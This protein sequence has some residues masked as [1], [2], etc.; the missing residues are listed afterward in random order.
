M[1][2]QGAGKAWLNEEESNRYNL[3]PMPET[4]RRNVNWTVVAGEHAMG[5]QLVP[6]SRESAG[7]THITSA[8]LSN[9]SAGDVD[10]VLRDCVEFA[11]KVIQLER[12]A[13]FLLAPDGASMIGTWGTD[14]RGQTTDEH[15]LTFDVDEL[16]LRTNGPTWSVYENCPLMTHEGGRSKSLG[17]GWTA[18][19][20]IWGSQRPVGVLFNDN[21][22]TRKPLDETK[23]ARAALLCSLI[24]RGIEACRQSLSQ[25]GK[26]GDSP[27]HPLVRIVT[28]TLLRDPSLSFQ[29]VAD[30][31]HVSK[32][33]LTR[34]FK[35]HADVSI[36]DYRNEVRLAKFLS[37]AN[38][39]GLLDAALA[40]GFG[41][42]AQ[43]HRVFRARF[44][45]SPRKH[46]F[47]LQANVL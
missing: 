1:F 4:Q 19:T 26:R 17:R 9:P 39:K 38:H 45:R 18:C 12:A 8:L 44:G 27:Q 46:L 16:F 33:H 14:S 43:F 47:E 29:E 3:G 40:A 31:L 25:E 36:V 42:Y 34:T 22:I 5:S 35:R 23:Q 41:S 28:R 6:P 37:L 2:E 30:R 10:R 15:D 20:P 13:I 24:G 21:A 32:G 11:R 7:L